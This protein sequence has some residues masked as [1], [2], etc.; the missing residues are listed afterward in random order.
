MTDKIFRKGLEG[1]IFDQTK[2]SKAIPDEQKL[3]YR[4]YNA[5]EL[6]QKC[7]FE[8]VA[9]LIRFGELPNSNELQSFNKKEKENRALS[10]RMIDLLKTISKSSHPMDSLRTA[11][12]FLGTEEL[13]YGQELHK[14]LENQTDILYAKAP[15]IVAADLRI[16][17][18][19]EVI[20]PDA[21]MDYASNFFHMCFGE[22]PDSKIVKALDGSLT[23]YAEHGFNASTFTARVVVS[24][25]SDIFSG[26]TAAIGALKGPL[27]GGA[28]EAVMEMLLKIGEPKKAKEFLLEKLAN[29]EKVMGFGHRLYRTGD[30]R[31]PQMTAFRDSVANIIGTPEANKWIEISNILEQTMISEKNIYPNL[32]FPAGPAYYLMKFPIPFFTP[33]FAMARITGWSAHIKEQLSDNKLVRPRSEYIGEMDKRISK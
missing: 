27:H 17:A 21:S 7:S 14:D 23:L 22:V 30:S 18:G 26:V 5:H 3:I 1:V 15:S 8:E 19:K 29:K 25:L 2:I 28:N 20:Q 24:T 4:G 16:R 6:A 33:I 32:D 31:V 10:N 12:S 13:S 9:F 11:I